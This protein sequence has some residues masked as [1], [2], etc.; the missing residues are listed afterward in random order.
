M[1][2]Y[3]EETSTVTTISAIDKLHNKNKLFIR[4]PSNK[5]QLPEARRVSCKNKKENII[6]YIKSLNS[7]YKLQY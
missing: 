4:T 7:K 5:Q 2:N 6:E 1:N 3:T